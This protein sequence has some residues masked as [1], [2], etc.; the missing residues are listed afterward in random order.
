ME[1]HT[2]RRRPLKRSTLMLWLDQCNALKAQ[3]TSVGDEDS[4]KADCIL[5]R[6]G[7]QAEKTVKFTPPFTTGISVAS[8]AWGH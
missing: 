1:L 7:E 2:E 4:H 5:A 6:E 3:R 8:P